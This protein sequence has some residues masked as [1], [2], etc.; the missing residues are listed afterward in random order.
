MYHTE[1]KMLN[2]VLNGEILLKCLTLCLFPLLARIAEWQNVPCQ[3]TG[4][5]LGNY[6]PYQNR[7]IA[8]SQNVWK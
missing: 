8:Q 2:P 7:R 5:M 4:V 6:T 1:R 3:I